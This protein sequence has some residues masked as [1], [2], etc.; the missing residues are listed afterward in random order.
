MIE[1]MQ[2]N[3]EMTYPDAT[4]D[5]AFEVLVDPEFRKAVCKATHALD[6]TVTVERLDDG[7]ASIVIDRTMPADLPDVAKKFIGDTVEVRQTEHW[8]ARSADGSRTADIE[9]K[10][11]GQPAGMI[12]TASLEPAGEGCREV[13]AGDVKVSIPFVGKKIEPEVARGIRAAVEIEQRVG[14]SWLG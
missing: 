13:I 1:A 2:L 3:A 4:P 10:I 9:V 7:G 6:F 12:G 5:E 11:E 14:L 8:G